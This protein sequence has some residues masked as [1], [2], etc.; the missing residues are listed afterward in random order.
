MTGGVFARPLLCFDTAGDQLLVTLALAGRAITHRREMRHGQAEELLPVIKNIL[1]TGSVEMSQVQGIFIT[2]GPGSFTGLRVAVAAAIGLGFGWGVGSS[3]PSD[4]TID[5]G[6]DAK[7]IYGIGNLPAMLITHLGK[8]GHDGKSFLVMAESRR[9][10]IFYQR[11]MVDTTTDGTTKKIAPL[12]AAPMMEYK[13][14]LLADYP[15]DKVV[16]TAVDFEIL[17]A[18]LPRYHGDDF[19]TDNIT[20]LYARPADTIMLK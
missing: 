17:L 10:E 5:I 14:K 3:A 12:T 7:K 19:I 4:N 1:Q 15:E 18:N 13:K 8:Q 9:D 16:M 2:L 11:F 6:H 20:P